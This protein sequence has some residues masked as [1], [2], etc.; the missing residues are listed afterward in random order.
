MSGPAD[1]GHEMRFGFSDLSF[2]PFRNLHQTR[3]FQC[4]D[5][6]LD[7]FIR[8]QEVRVYERQSLG[9]TTLVYVEGRM[10]AFYTISMDGLRFQYMTRRKPLREPNI[11]EIEVIPALK[12]VRL[13][14]HLDYQNHGIGRLLLDHLVG[15]ALRQEA[16]CRLIIVNARPESIPFYEKYGFRLSDHRKIKGRREKLMFFDLDYVRNL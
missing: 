8:S 11:I 7:E 13:A 9:R 6:A 2:E 15:F 5:E 12:I 3:G 4:G 1:F 14:V 16:A 10:V